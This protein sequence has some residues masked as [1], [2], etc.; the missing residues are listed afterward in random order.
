MKQPLL[1]FLYVLIF[2]AICFGVYFLIAFITG[3]F[4]RRKA[5]RILVAV[6]LS[7][8]ICVLG[9]WFLGTEPENSVTAQ[10]YI[11]GSPAQV[12]SIVGKTR[13]ET[14]S[15]LGDPTDSVENEYYY[16][17]ARHEGISVE[18]ENG[19]VYKVYHTGR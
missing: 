18:F 2:V 3:K 4:I 1:V 7:I 16:G 10:K 19:K 9:M 11:S 13:S 15:L 6:P 8:L 5:I 17:I 12:D 14:R